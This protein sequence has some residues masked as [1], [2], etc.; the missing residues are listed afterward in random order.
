MH[1]HAVDRPEVPPLTLS[2][3]FRTEIVYFC[4]PA[5]ERGAPRDLADDEYWIDLVEA[6]QWLD[7]YVIQ[8]VSPL[9]AASKAEI[10]LSEDHEAFLQW[11]LDHG[12]SRVR[13]G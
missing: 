3:R 11:L 9:D 10:E 7:N 1:V 8:V 2:G 12:V 5:G 6:Q 4:T 13:T